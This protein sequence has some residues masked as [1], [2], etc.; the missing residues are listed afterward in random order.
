M[1]TVAP[2]SGVQP[3]LPTCETRNVSCSGVPSFTAPLVGSERMS[4]RLSFSSTKYGPS[5]SAGLTTH[6]G[7]PAGAASVVAAEAT[8]VAASVEVGVAAS[9]ATAV[10][11]GSVITVFVEPAV[12]VL[13]G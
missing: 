13:A 6:A 11:D 9:V 7:T 3:L 8:C 10:L 5:V 12:A 1:S 4:E 2:A